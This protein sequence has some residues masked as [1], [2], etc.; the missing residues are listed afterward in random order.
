[1]L[2]RFLDF[3]SSIAPSMWLRVSFLVLIQSFQFVII[4][5]YLL[6]FFPLHPAVELTVNRIGGACPHRGPQLYALGIL[7]F[8]VTFLLIA[9]I[10]FK[11]IPKDI[12]NRQ[13][14]KPDRRARIYGAMLVESIVLILLLA[15]LNLKLVRNSDV[16]RKS[17]V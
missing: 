2:N 7:F 9:F 15:G 8:N 16:D 14:H 13:E 12:G 1:M 11:N 6:S 17:V 5:G 10:G 3:I 4:V